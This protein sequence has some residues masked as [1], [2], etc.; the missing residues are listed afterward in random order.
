MAEDVRCTLASRRGRTPGREEQRDE[1]IWLSAWSRTTGAADARRSLLSLS[2][3]QTRTLLARQHQPHLEIP[4]PTASTASMHH[5]NPHNVTH[6]TETTTQFPSYLTDAQELIVIN[7]FLNGETTNPPADV[8]INISAMCE[9]FDLPVSEY[10][11]RGLSKAFMRDCE[12][13]MGVS[14]G[15]LTTKTPR[16]RRP[17]WAHRRIAGDCAFYISLE[18]ASWS[19]HV[20]WDAPRTQRPSWDEMLRTLAHEMQGQEE[21]EIL[22]ARWKLEDIR[23]PA[24]FGGAAT[25][26]ATPAPQALLTTEIPAVIES[27]ISQAA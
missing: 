20:I 7:W 21:T 12:E 11:N 10:M 19:D 26:N 17:V 2:P 18:F 14:P 25:I 1:R 5:M 9:A 15:S 16:S 23:R 4:R 22:C 8:F 6:T 3:K 13:E 27:D 24:N